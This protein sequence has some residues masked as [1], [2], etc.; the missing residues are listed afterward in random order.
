MNGRRNGLLKIGEVSKSSGIGI[1][2]LRFY[3][4]SGLLEKPARTRSGYR[5][6]S[7]NVLDR[8]AFIKQ[9]QILGFTLDEIKQIIAA[10]ESK[11]SPCIEVR[12]NVRRRLQEMDERIAQMRRY[13]KELG[14]A[15]EKWNE[16]KTIEG[17]ICGL[18]E[19]SSIKQPMPQTKLVGKI[20]CRKK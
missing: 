17:D 7:S 14:A 5:I 15:L 18:I 1:E 16:D 19:S 9:A 10:S 12:E 13:R 6:Y 8:L 2:A 11:E 20:R 3:E 4:K